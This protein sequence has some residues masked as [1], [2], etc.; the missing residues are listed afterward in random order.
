MRASS[1]QKYIEKSHADCSGDRL[2]Y[3]GADGGGGGDDVDHGGGGD[4][5]HGGDDG[6]GVDWDMVGERWVQ[7]GFIRECANCVADRV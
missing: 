5:D 3:D 2:W 6:D 1:V 4:G 7:A